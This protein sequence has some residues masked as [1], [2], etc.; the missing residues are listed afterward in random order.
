MTGAVMTAL[1]LVA[2]GVTVAL[3]VVVLEPRSAS[4]RAT[5]RRRSARERAPRRSAV[6]PRDRPL[7]DGLRVVLLRVV[8]A[9]VGVLALCVAADWA[10]GAAWDEVRGGDPDP[11]STE[12]A[13]TPLPPADDPRVDHPALADAPWAD[14]YFAE[15]EALEFT[16]IPFIGPREATVQ[17]RYVSSAEG[18]RGSYE[19]TGALAADAPEV[20]FFGGSALWG[21]GQR[22]RHT[23][24]SEVARLA[25][26]DGTPIRVVNYGLRGYTALQELLLFEQEVTRRGA[27][28]L[29]VFYHG[30]NELSTQTAAPENLGA[31]PTIFQLEVTADAFD[32]A[33]ARPGQLAGAEPS[34]RQEYVQTSALH[35]L[36]REVQALAAI[37]PAAAD[38]PFYVPPAD[39]MAEAVD[40]AEAIYRRTMALLGHVASAHR[41][42]TAV[43]W[44]PTALWLPYEDLTER[45]ATIGGGVD[46][47][48]TLDDAPSPVFLDGVHTNELGARLVAEAMWPVL[49][50]RL[51]EGDEP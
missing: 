49:A 5:G 37:A 43:F 31:Q 36:W 39:E 10:L 12:L 22:D 40:H 48:E 21:E 13:A 30:F 41:V 20:W 19:P 33:P 46:L 4:S 1:V 26:A 6:A 32:R 9:A 2:V 25:E 7:L 11:R 18:I 17:G 27:P 14:R 15:L 23:I 3:Q 24:P 51:A 42:P 29:A 8:P 35:K 50:G 47:S 44:Q 45:V 16:Y 38:E 34:V 28:D